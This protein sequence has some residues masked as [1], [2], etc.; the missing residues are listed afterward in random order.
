MMDTPLRS[1]RWR[2]LLVGIG[3]ALAVGIIAA[4]QSVD[5]LITSW[6]YGTIVWPDRVPSDT[7]HFVDRLTTAAETAFAFWG[8][9][10]PETLGSWTSR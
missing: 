10:P 7:G 8:H 1:W 9:D 6:A 5:Y 2:N 3:L 4:A